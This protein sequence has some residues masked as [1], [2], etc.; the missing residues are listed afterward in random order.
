MTDFKASVIKQ[1]LKIIER[2]LDA[3]GV[4]QHRR[5]SDFIAAGGNPE[6]FAWWNWC[7]VLFCLAFRTTYISADCGVYHSGHGLASRSPGHSLLTRLC[8]Y[9]AL[10]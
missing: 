5:P 10:S 3:D 2:P 8:Y 6:F 1:K 4:R 9:N 7:N